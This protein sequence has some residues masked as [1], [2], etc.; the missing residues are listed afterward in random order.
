[1]RC[2]LC[3]KEEQ[4]LLRVIIEGAEMR[5][6]S[7]CALYGK[8][9]PEEKKQQPV[10]IRTKGRY[11]GKDVFEKMGKELVPDW[12]KIIKKARE[13]KEISREKLGAL[14]GEKTT[15]IAKIENQE[16]RPSDGKAKK[17]EKVLDV[18]LFQEVEGTV[19]KKREK[20]SLT[21][22]DILGKDE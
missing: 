18:V 1:M 12:G 9:V 3:G 6:C 19:I 2:E 7:G 13:M 10:S 11:Y 14:V 20:K 15:T 21:I 4:N 8:V 17:I 5:V 22:G 16:L